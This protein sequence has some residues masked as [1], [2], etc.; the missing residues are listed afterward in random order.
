MLARLF[1]NLREYQIG[2]ESLKS[3]SLIF[4]RKA[5]APD[6]AKVRL[7]LSLVQKA[8][9]GDRGAVTDADLG[10]GTPDYEVLI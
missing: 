3:A 9:N 8:I 2:Q 5:I 4:P 6:V 10:I 7:M 1:Q